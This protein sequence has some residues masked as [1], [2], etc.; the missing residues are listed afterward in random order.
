MSNITGC[1]LTLGHISRSLCH[2]II[3]NLE[4]LMP[5]KFLTAQGVQKIYGS[6]SAL[7]RNQVLQEEVSRVFQSIELELTSSA[8]S[9]LGA[10]I[11]AAAKL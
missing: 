3:T 2:G 11:Y 6:G 1:N 4:E 7:L 10:A 9:A 8:D 5:L